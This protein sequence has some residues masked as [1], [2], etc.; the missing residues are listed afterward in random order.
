MHDAFKL[1]E[2]HES[3][4]FRQSQQVKGLF[5]TFSPMQVNALQH[6]QLCFAEFVVHNGE[7]LQKFNNEKLELPLKTKLEFSLES[8]TR[9]MSR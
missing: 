1:I 6:V 9:F 7:Q 2:S 5:C 8:F 4:I 3:W